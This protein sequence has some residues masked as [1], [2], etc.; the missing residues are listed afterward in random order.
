MECLSNGKQFEI[1]RQQFHCMPV[2][3]HLGFCKGLIL[4]AAILPQRPDFKRKTNRVRS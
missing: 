3:A 4:L 1:Q 2:R